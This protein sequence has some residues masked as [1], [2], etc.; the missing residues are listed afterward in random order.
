MGTRKYIV[1][2][3]FVVALTLTNATTKETYERTYNGGEEVS[4]DDDDAKLHLHKLEFANQKDRD[5]ALAAEKE[6]KAAAS[7]DQNP[8]DLIAQLVAAIAQQSA[9]TPAK[10]ALKADPQVPAA[11]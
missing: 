8:V 6:A 5:A 7:S 4:L 9:K 10:T 1:R 3:G 11:T 2:D